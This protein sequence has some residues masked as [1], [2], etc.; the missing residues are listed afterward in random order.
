MAIVQLANSLVDRD[1]Q[2]R[3]VHFPLTLD[4]NTRDFKRVEHEENIK[5]CIY[6]LIATR[7]GERVMAED[8]GTL[9]MQSLFASIEGLED[10]LPFQVT[11]AITLYEPRVEDIR[12]KAERTG[13]TELRLTT[14]WVVRATG[15]RDSLVYPYFVE[16]SR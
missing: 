9:I 7:I 14:T 11:E 2:G 6:W 15:R 3:G 8:V 13:L 1:T 16:G 12:A 10:T 4:A 5:E